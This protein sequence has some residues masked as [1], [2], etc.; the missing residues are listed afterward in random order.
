VSFTG[1]GSAAVLED[2]VVPS[3]RVVC[4]RSFSRAGLPKK[5]VSSEPRV[6]DSCRSASNRRGA[7]RAS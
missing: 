4:I 2:I 7:S 1:E 5:N 6:R 3:F